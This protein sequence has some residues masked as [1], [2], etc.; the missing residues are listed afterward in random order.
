MACNGT[1]GC[2]QTNQSSSTAVA[3]NM[4]PPTPSMIS[5]SYGNPTT[6]KVIT[7]AKKKGQ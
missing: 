7:F 3:A 2:G 6:K 4:R 1:P 5:S